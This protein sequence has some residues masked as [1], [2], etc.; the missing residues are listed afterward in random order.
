VDPLASIAAEPARAGV[1]LDIDGV[2]APIVPRPEDA[3]VPDETRTELRRLV[4]RY[5]LVACVTGRPSSVARELVGVPE[6][7]YVGEHGLELDARAQE[8]GP[9]IQAFAA[10]SRQWST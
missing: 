7:T 10:V 1:F 6:L 8:W 2:L 9:R 5:R 3:R 4:G